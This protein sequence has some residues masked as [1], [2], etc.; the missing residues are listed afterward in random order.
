MNGILLHQSDDE[1]TARERVITMTNAL[2]AAEVTYRKE[3]TLEEQG[4]NIRYIIR[5]TTQKD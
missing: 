1:D 2:Y 3:Y 4:D 5:I